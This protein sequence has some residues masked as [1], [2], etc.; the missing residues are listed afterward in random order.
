MNLVS[1]PGFL[2]G[3]CSHFTKE[4]RFSVLCFT[5]GGENIA[6]QT[7]TVRGIQKAQAT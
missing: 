5:F 7:S 3:N 6:S 1:L 4:L 2:A